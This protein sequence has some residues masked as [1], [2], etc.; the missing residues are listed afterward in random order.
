M[1]IGIIGA[2]FIGRTLARLAMQHGYE[3]M[4]SNSRG[5]AS[6]TSTAR[7]IHARTGTVEEA[8]AFGD[9]VVLAIPFHA[10]ASL[11]A[12]ALAGKVA[13]DAMNYYPDRDGAIPELDRR[14]TTTSGMISSLL[15]SVRIVKAFNA[16]LANDLEAGGRLAGDGG[17]RA[18]PVAADDGDAKALVMQFQERIGF[19]AVDTGGLAE[20]WR[21]ERGKP[22][23][24]VGLDR[25]GVL[26]A[27]AAAHRDDDLPVPRAEPP[28]APSLSPTTPPDWV[29]AFFS[30]IDRKDFGRSFGACLA[31]DAQMRFGVHDVRGR[32]IIAATLQKFDT[33][34]ETVHRVLDYWDAGPLKFLRGEVTMTKHDGSPPQTPAFVHV[35]HMA[36]G[37]SD[38]VMRMDGAVGPSAL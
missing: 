26:Q 9:I 16:I 38:K 2:G 6:L 31:D 20:S 22:A 11:P 8:A 25:A 24:C 19:D 29:L 35:W 21:F 7:A 4:V 33:D 17:R 27:L 10:R 15:P 3:A 14:E 30:D 1:K 12:A 34:M 28:A 5:P 36:E 23:Y 18:I 13:V 32:E 37:T